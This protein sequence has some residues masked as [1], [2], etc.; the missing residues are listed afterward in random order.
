MTRLASP[1]ANIIDGDEYSA[2][3]TTTTTITAWRG[4]LAQGMDAARDARKV[5]ASF[6]DDGTPATTKARPPSIPFTS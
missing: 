2:G 5:T 6:N 3:S 1:V 4:R